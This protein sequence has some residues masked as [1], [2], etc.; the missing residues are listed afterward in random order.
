MNDNVF[1]R[2]RII[3]SD[4]WALERIKNS[5]KRD[6]IITIN[7]KFVKCFRKPMVDATESLIAQLKQ[8]YESL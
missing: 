1:E 5:L 8:E 6:D 7:L 4:L 2:A 3:K